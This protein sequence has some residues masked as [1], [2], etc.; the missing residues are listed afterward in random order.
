MSVLSCPIARPIASTTTTCKPALQAAFREYRD[1]TQTLPR[2]LLTP[3]Q[4]D[5]GG[6]R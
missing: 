2:L 4:A 1:A 5:P 3:R 6:A